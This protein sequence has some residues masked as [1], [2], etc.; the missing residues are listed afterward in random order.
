[1]NAELLTGLTLI[2]STS[3]TNSSKQKSTPKEKSTRKTSHLYLSTTSDILI[4]LEAA[5]SLA[6]RS[7]CDVVVQNDLSV[8]FKQDATKPVLE[9]ILVP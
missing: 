8:V 9:T 6:R 1:M 4:A 5:E 7:N 2:G 3:G